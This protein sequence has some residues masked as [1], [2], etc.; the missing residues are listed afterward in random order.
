MYL[1]KRNMKTNK[2]Y[3]DSARTFTYAFIGIVVMLIIALLT[4]CGTAKTVTEKIITEV[5]RIENE[6]PYI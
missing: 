1:K 6:L 4:G 2:Q 5:N 3:E